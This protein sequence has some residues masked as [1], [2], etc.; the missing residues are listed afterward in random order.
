MPDPDELRKHLAYEVHYL[1][2]AAVRFTEISGRD[3]T[4]YQDSALLH[5]RNLL[6]FTKPGQRPRYGWWIKDVG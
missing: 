4:L 1:V 2:L 6:E 5:A 3:G